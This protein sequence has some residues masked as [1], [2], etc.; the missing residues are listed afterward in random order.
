MAH[1]HDDA[2]ELAAAD[3]DALWA[4]AE[5]EVPSDFAA[6]VGELASRS[7][8]AEPRPRRRGWRAFGMA[9]GLAMAAGLLATLWLARGATSEA[10]DVPAV[11]SS[12]DIPA[13]RVRLRDDVRTLLAE[14]CVPCHAHGAPGA[15]DAALAVFDVDDAAWAD[16]L[17]GA[18]LETAR[19]RFAEIGLDE[20]VEA[21][22]DA[23]VER[24]LSAR[25]RGSG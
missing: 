12:T 23:F 6:R 13:D 7:V 24:E 10:S 2:F 19:Q 15:Q 5:A 14:H 20:G 4:W 17:T 9:S 3:R 8:C 11:A 21:R 25:R 18:Q 16:R 1:E 22:V